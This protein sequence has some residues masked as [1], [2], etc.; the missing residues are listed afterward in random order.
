MNAMLNGD[1]AVKSQLSKE[2]NCVALHARHG[3]L[4][5]SFIMRNAL[6][7]GIT[8]AMSTVSGN[9]AYKEINYV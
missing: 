1:G 6:I 9:F 4:P 3:A 5:L 8:I 7:S 2:Y